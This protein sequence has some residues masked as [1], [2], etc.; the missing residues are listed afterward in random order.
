MPRTRIIDFPRPTAVHHTEPQRVSLLTIDG[1]GNLTVLAADGVSFTCDWLENGQAVAL[2][3]GDTLL[4]LPP[5]AS[6][7]G[8][9]LGRIGPYREPQPVARLTLEATE[10]L[11]LRC[12]DVTIDLRAADGKLML[13]GDDVLLRAKGTQRIRAGTVAIN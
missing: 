9:V 10:V 6:G 7:R 4:A 1:I 12:G 5:D 8:I 13:R 2:A 3:T 11:T